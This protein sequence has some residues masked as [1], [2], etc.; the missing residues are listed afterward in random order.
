MPKKYH[1]NTEHIPP[2]FT[3]VGK[4]GIV[5][6]NEDCAGACH[7]CVKK[8]CIYEIYKKEGIFTR[9]MEGPVHYLYSCMNCLRCVQ[10]C[11]RAAITRVVNP[12]FRWLGDDYWKPDIILTLWYQSET[13]K[14]PVS[15]AGYR[16]KFSGPGFDSMWTD[17]SEIVRPTRDGIHGREY[18]STS[19]DVGR[20]VPILAF[21]DKRRTAVDIPPLMELPVP[22][23]LSKPPFGDYSPKMYEAFARA[24]A[25]LETQFVLDAADITKNLAKYKKHIAPLVRGAEISK[26]KKLIRSAAFVELIY[27]GKMAANIKAIKKINT[28]AVV[29]VKIPLDVNSHRT[30]EK[31]TDAGV[32]VIHFTADMHGNIGKGEHPEFIKDNFRRIH[33]HLVDRGIRDCV[34]L[35]AEGGI[36]LPEHMAKMI[37]CGADV[38]ALGIPFLVA[39]E[40]RMC[41]NCTRGRACPVDISGVPPESGSKRILNLAAAW[42]NQLLEVLG[43]MGIREVRRL[44]GEFGRAMFYEDLERDTFRKI[45]SKDKKEKAKL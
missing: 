2:R 32:E 45:F 44:R 29:S 23:V 40:C 24:A 34:T 30:A 36:A 13:G 27:D 21:D 25:V 28:N 4:F 15:G 35:I 37:I 11:T 18:I 1:I 22:F 6:F 16:G 42:R 33:T 19:V 26:Y 8:E 10:N 38:V 3:P 9:E 20:K 43:A 39:I 17:M 12:E 31:L 41:M 5:D 7:H 14:I